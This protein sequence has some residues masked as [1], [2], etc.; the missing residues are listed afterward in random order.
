M[1]DKAFVATFDSER[2]I[3][4]AARAARAKGMTVQDAYTPYPVH[5]MD[6]AL[7]LV[8]S[9]SPA[10]VRL[11]SRAA[12][13]EGYQSASEDL[14]TQANVALEGRQIQRLVNLV[15]PAVAAQLEQG[16]PTRPEP[17]PI[18]YVEADGTGR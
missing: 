8:H 4:A 14:L 12:A 18:L 15:A 7:G 9:F 2:G 3:L 1:A 16:H 10:V 11:A 13:K 17:L 5:G 6:Q